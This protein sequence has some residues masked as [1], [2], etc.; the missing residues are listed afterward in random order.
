MAL[1]TEMQKIRNPL[2]PCASMSSTSDALEHLD[3][4]LDSA[5]TQ[6]HVQ[7]LDEVVAVNSYFTVAVFIGLSFTNPSSQ[8]SLVGSCPADP[9]FTKLLLIFEVISFSSFLL[10]S[11][12]AQALK[13]LIVLANSK[14][15]A[16]AISAQLNPKLLRF[17]MLVSAIGTVLGTIFLTLSMV[18]LIQIRLG[19]LNCDTSSWSKLAAIPMVVMVTTGL[20]TFISAALYAFVT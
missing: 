20:L 8:G 16:E 1:P 19:L 9:D 11:L 15:H 4:R 5:L 6:V 2:F 3:H 12:I 14:N 10:S 13:L 7:A 17:G 18:Y